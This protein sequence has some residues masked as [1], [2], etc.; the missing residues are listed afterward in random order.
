MILNE[1][2]RSYCGCGDA[3][4]SQGTRPEADCN[5][6]CSGDSTQICGGGWT[7]SVYEIV[8]VWKCPGEGVKN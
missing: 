3:Y 4:G 7:N 6:P 8:P 2:I 5:M 1:Q